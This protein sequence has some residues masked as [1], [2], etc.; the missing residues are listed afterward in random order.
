MWN[1]SAAIGHHWYPLALVA[2]S[3][4]QSWLGGKLRTM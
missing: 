3:L 1:A 4:P 2:L